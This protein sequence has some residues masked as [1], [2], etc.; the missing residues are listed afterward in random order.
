LYAGVPGLQGTDTFLLNTIVSS[1]AR[2][3]RLCDACALF[4]AILPP[5]SAP[6]TRSLQ[7][8][9]GR[10]TAGT[11]CCSSDMYA[12]CEQPEEARK[13]FKAM[14]ERNIVTWNS[15]ITCYEQ[16]GPLGEALVL[17]L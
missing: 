11:H 14:P 13:V 10:G 4:E 17:F 8:S 12:K 3:G 9:C 16:N 15:L 2:L 7:R 6:T 5:T 1:Y